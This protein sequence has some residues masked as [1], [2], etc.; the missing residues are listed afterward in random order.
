MARRRPATPPKIPNAPSLSFLGSGGFADVYLYE[1]QIPRREV[2]IKV[3]RRGVADAQ[4]QSF[5]A[6]ANLM[7]RMSSHP[8]IVS[9]YGAGE[10]GDERMY[11]IMEYCPPPHLGARLRQQPFTVTHAL[12]IGIQIG[13]AIETLHRAGIVHRDIKPSNILMTPFQRP[14]LTDFGIATRIGNVSPAEGFSVP[15]APPEQATGEGAAAVT[16]DVYSLAAT[17]YTLLAGRPPFEVKDG[18]NSEIAVINRVLRTP[19]PPMGRHDVPEEFERVLTIAMSKDPRQRYASVI[20][21]A[22]ALQAIQAALHQRP[23]D[24]DVLDDPAYD[25]PSKSGDDADAT[26]QAI[27]TIDPLRDDSTRLSPLRVLGP[28]PSP[29]IRAFPPASEARSYD[30]AG[31]R[32]PFDSALPGDA[33]G[34]LGGPAEAET[35]RRAGVQRL[36]RAPSRTPRTRAP[37][38]SRRA[39]WASWSSGSSSPPP[40]CSP[41]SSA[42][43]SPCGTARAGRSGRRPRRGRRRPTT[44]AS[45][46][47]ARSSGCAASSWGT[48][49]SSRGAT[50][51]PSPGTNSSTRWT[52]SPVRASSTRRRRRALPSPSSP[53]RRACPCGCT[54]RAGRSRL[55][56]GSA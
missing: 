9:V 10:A 46:T 8:S 11:L 36:R 3:L 25:N 21:F 54:G 20:D 50:P 48:R 14:V 6:E 37:A 33:G 45:T 53:S 55:P 16:V 52:R 51:T 42:S 22:R 4:R 13:G 12:E 1:Q 41:S 24:L 32:A 18:D 38:D 19:V 47:S 5:R 23:T 49:S 29:N 39:L 30:A 44:Q 31:Q 26:R 56:P 7:A 35:G 34:S 43:S 15:W 17:V 27:R 2:A 28:V 40:L